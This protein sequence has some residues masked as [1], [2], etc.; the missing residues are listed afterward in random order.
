MGNLYL[1]PTINREVK[2]QPQAQVHF[3]IRN[4]KA[5]SGEGVY[6]KLSPKQLQHADL[7]ISIT[8]TTLLV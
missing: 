7:E 2:Y 6:A 4:D 8:L 3:F 5:G 1:V